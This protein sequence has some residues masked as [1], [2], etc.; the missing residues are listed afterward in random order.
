MVILELLIS[1]TK[2]IAMFTLIGVFCVFL[3]FKIMFGVSSYFYVRGLDFYGPVKSY[4]DTLNVSSTFKPMFRKIKITPT[5][6]SIR[7]EGVFGNS[8]KFKRTIPCG[9]LKH[10]ILIK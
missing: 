8:L 2:L 7:V 9:D 5:K 1:S 4:K 10:E 6:S 3:V